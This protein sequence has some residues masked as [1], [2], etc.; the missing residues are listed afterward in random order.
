MYPIPTLVV[1]YR[2]IMGRVHA[3][4]QNVFKLKETEEAQTGKSWSARVRSSA[5]QIRNGWKEDTSFFS[6]ANKGE[7]E[8]VATADANL[9]KR[10]D[11]F[12]IGFEPLFLDFTKS[13]AWFV[14]VSLVQ[15]RAM[16]SI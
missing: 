16:S 3:D 6:W 5:S 7:W 10:V 4:G 1:V 15:V 2:A 12:R 14:I 8:T 11:S 9:Q 13:G